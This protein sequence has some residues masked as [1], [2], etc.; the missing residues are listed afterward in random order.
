M[1][2]DD[3]ETFIMNIDVNTDDLKYYVGIS[4]ILESLNPPI[5]SRN[6]YCL[7]TS[8]FD[9]CKN[10]LKKFIHWPHSL[11]TVRGWWMTFV[12]GVLEVP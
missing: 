9:A 6:V 12:M 1:T 3:N 11:L 10:N 7:T 5:M 2:N 8:N 4:D